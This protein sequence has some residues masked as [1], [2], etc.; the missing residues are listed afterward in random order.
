M[1]RRL[2]D[3]RA[4]GARVLS[5]ILGETVRLKTVVRTVVPLVPVRHC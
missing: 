2:P 1:P 3:E 4:F 5:E